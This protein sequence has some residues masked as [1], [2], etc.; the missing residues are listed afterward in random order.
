MRNT[1]RNIII[2]SVLTALASCSGIQ[3]YDDAIRIK[4]EAAKKYY[5]NPATDELRDGRTLKGTVMRMQV[6][7]IPDTCPITDKTSFTNTASAIFLDEDSPDGSGNFE[8]IPLE[9]IESVGRMFD[10]PE[11][12]YGNINYFENYNNPDR[13]RSLREVPVDT[14]MVDTCCPCKCIPFDLDIDL[15]LAFNLQCIERNFLWFFLEVRGGYAVY[16]DN[17]DLFTL[18]ARESFPFEIA[19]G[20]RFGGKKEWGL[21][22]AFSSG[23]KSY[24]AFKAVDLLRPVILLH[25]RYQSPNDKFLGLCMRPFAYAQFGVTID[26]LSISLFDFN[27]NTKCDDC[28]RYLEGLE[29][30]GQLPGID[31]S[32]P[33]SFGIGAGFEIPIIPLMDLSVDIGFRSLA[34][35]EAAIIAGFDNVPSMRRVNM[36]IFRFGFTI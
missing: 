9:D 2:L 35:G 31:F 17:I 30:S 11:N 15:D 4:E 20:A 1:I 18:E 34:F 26:K 23:V 3:R 27:F 29:E 36:M 28:K 24:N 8:L 33:L 21:G 16:N 22:M 5:K 7:S 19:W 13:M 6:V 32:M 25:G 10:M 12:K 14:I